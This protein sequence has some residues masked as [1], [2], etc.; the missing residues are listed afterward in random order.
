MS[1]RKCTYMYDYIRLWTTYYD[2][3]FK[4]VRQ[5]STMYANV[6]QKILP[7]D[8]IF[9]APK[10]FTCKTFFLIRSIAYEN[11]RLTANNRDKSRQHTK[12]YDYLIRTLSHL[13]IRMWETSI[14]IL[15]F[16]V[17]S[18]SIRGFVGYIL[19]NYLFFYSEVGD[20]YSTTVYNILQHDV[21]PCT[22]MFDNVRQKWLPYNSIFAAPKSFTWKTF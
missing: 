2:T 19:A 20:V 1:V 5:C 8:R 15:R 16:V 11:L 14:N 21:Q 6:R 3:M 9:V 7:Y 13:K 10:S 12:N 4:S 18:Q 17:K 22:T